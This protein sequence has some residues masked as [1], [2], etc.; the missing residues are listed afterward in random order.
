M[1]VAITNASQEKKRWMVENKMSLADHVTVGTH[2]SGTRHPVAVRHVD[3]AESR[4][5]LS[6]VVAMG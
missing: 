6:A 5:K 1:S 4:A 3:E 2:W